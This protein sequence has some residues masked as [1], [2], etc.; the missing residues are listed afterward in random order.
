MTF[1]IS[2]SGGAAIG[3]AGG[4]LIARLG[5][6]IENPMIGNLFRLLTPF[7]IFFLA[8]M[9]EASGVLAVVVCGLYMTQVG[10]KF[11]STGSRFVARP[12]WG[13]VATYILN[14]L[15]FFLMGY[16]LP[17]IAKNLSSDTLTHALQAMVV[18]YLVMLLARCIFMELSIYTIRMLDRRPSQRAHR[19]TFRDRLVSSLAGFRG[20]IS[21]A[22][23]LSI[24]AFLADGEA[25]PS[26]DVVIFVTSG[27]VILSLVVQGALLP[28]AVRWQQ[29]NP[30]VNWGE[31]SLLQEKEIRGAM[32]DSMRNIAKNL[33][34]IAVENEISE[35]ITDRVRQEM[36]DQKKSWERARLRWSSCPNGWCG[37]FPWRIAGRDRRLP[38]IL[39]LPVR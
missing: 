13:G 28:L 22:V 26:R 20:G 23:A 12:F 19:T 21:L 17:E 2:F 16:V 10:P 30:N 11:Q 4:W 7:L 18:L 29:A 14:S 39:Y 32:I 35:E 6:P 15:L 5:A 3:F 31:E 34:S 8:E 9:V 27:I 24:P 36:T 1:L 37:A 33:D 38:C 25:F